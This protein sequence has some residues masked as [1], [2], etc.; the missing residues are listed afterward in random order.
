M[1]DRYNI[2]MGFYEPALFRLHTRG[3]GKLRDMKNWSVSQKSTFLHEYIHFLQDITTIQGFNNFYILGEYIRYVS[4]IVKQSATKEIKVPMN[5]FSA[6]Q[7]VDQNWIAR[8]STMG[9]NTPVKDV[10]SYSSKHILD[11]VDYNNGQKIPL[12]VV[13]LNCVD[14]R[15]YKVEVKLGTLHIMEGMAKLIQELVYP[16]QGRT[17]PYNPYYIASDVA[18][19]IIPGI[20][21]VPYTL[22]ALLDFALQTTNPGLTYVGYLEAKLREGYNAQSLTPEIIYAD[23]NNNKMNISS[24]G[25]LNFH[26]AYTAFQGGAED[27]MNEYLGGVWYWKNIEIWYKNILDRSRKIRLDNPYFFQS[28]IEGGDIANNRMFMDLQEMFGTPLTTNSNDFFDFSSPKNIFITKKEVINVYAM[29][30]IHRVFL[31]N[32]TF[33]CPLRKFCQNRRC[34]FFKQKVDKQ[35]VKQPWKRMRS[36]NRCYFNIW[37]KFKGFGNIHISSR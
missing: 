19:M 33:T 10:I 37:W 12:N 5:P 18:E 34:G 9:T 2:T 24:L 20:K 29:M 17:S 13:S 22:I 15:G 35:C 16:T 3:N 21:S 26:E 8:C 25:Q 28:L 31:S 11:L 27:V 4:Q 36:W 1:L 23:L 14:E 6:N 7:N 30:Q 32:G